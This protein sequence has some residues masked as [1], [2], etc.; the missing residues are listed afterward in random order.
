MAGESITPRISP[1]WSFG[2]RQLFLWTAAIALGLV[3]LR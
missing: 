3:A 1:R 2:L